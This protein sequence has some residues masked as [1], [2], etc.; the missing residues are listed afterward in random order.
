[1]KLIGFGLLIVL[2]DL[3]YDGVDVIFDLVG[4]AM[5]YAGAR[6]L[7][8]LDK[9]FRAAAGFAFL[10]ALLAVG[11]LLLR[12]DVPALEAIAWAGVAIPSCTGLLRITGDRRVANYASWLRSAVFV[13]V[14]MTLMIGWGTS[15]GG[16][17]GLIA[18]LT[19]ALALG[20]AVLFVLLMIS[21]GRAVTGGS[22]SIT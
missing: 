20:T 6:K 4:W 12:Q 16:G 5:A 3:R 9:A 8:P 21:G 10:G 17:L 19:I 2:V 1:M 13:S 7:Y 18:F 15:A 11:E 22:E 14:V